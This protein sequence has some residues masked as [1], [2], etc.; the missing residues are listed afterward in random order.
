LRPPLIGTGRNNPHEFGD[1]PPEPRFPL[2]L[3]F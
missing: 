2:H 1:T 3:R